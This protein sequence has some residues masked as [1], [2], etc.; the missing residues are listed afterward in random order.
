ML[1]LVYKQF[2]QLISVIHR[3]TFQSPQ[4]E[5]RDKFNQQMRQSKRLTVANNIAITTHCGK[6]YVNVVCLSQNSYCT[7]GNKAYML[8]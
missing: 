7:V 5:I 2:I 6:S 1:K 4:P 3:D 8:R